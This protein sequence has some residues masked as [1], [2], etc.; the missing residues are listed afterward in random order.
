MTR[1]SARAPRARRSALPLVFLA[2]AGS[3]AR[4]QQFQHQAGLLPGAVVWTEGV[5]CADVDGD[6]DLDVFFADGDG[7]NAP[8]TKRQ[9]VLLINQF[10]PTG[11]LT[12]TDE[13][14][15][16]LG[17]H[18][19]N[20]KAVVTCDVNGDGWI[21][22]LFCNAWDTDTPFLYI[23]QGPANP[24]VFTLESAARG[25][26]AAMSSGGAQF[27]D[28]DD[29]GDPDLLINDAYLGTAARR[30]KVYFN[31]GA[32]VFSNS[33]SAISAAPTKT[34]QMDTQ[35]VDVDNDWDLDFVGL[36]RAANGGTN[37]Y[38]LLNNGAGTFGSAPLTIP[39]NS[40]STYE[41]EVGDLDGDN[42]IDLFL[43]SSSGFAEGAIRNNLVP[44]GAL[45]LTAQATLVDGNDDNEIALLDYDV[46]GDYD[47][48]VGSL[49]NTRETFWTN[50]GA[51][52]F[53]NA[54][55]GVITAQTDSTLDLAV[56]DLDNDGRYDLVTGQGESGN[57]TNKVY[58]NTGAVDTRK[59]VVTALDSPAF[60][61]PAGPFKVHAKIRDQVLDDGVNYVKASARYVIR[62]TNAVPQGSS[63]D[64]AGL[65]NPSLSISAGDGVVWQN[66]L[67]APQT[68]TFTNAPYDHS[69]PTLAQ[70]QTFETALVHPGIYSYVVQP[71]GFAGTIT[72][73]GSDTAVAGTHSG[74][75]LY[76]FSMPDNVGGAGLV[77]HYELVFT[78]WAGN[79]RVTAPL[80]ISL[81]D[82][83][84]ATYC[85]AK[86][87]SLGCVPQITTSGT[88]NTT[89]SSGFTITASNVLNQ[90]NG[91]FFY[92]VNG[93]TAQPFDGGTLCVVGPH[94]RTTL[95]NSGGSVL[96]SD[97]SGAFAL[98]FNTYMAGVTPITFSVGTTVDGQFWSRDP[99]DPFATNITGGIHFGLCQ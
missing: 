86:T 36:C 73:A 20:A 37:H 43:V 25:L 85:T 13:S 82:C 32:G 49:S 74:G 89:A 38:L 76:R 54:G 53:T 57:F 88:P 29:D 30:P 48:I 61:L 60:V 68:I 33:T 55:A 21:D 35:L 17:V 7:F 31:N 28:L 84:I 72:V 62:T 71:A 27:G 63:I 47:V 44:N 67:A 26:T 79:T 91:L 42:D 50:N 23:N 75:Q 58:R 16:R 41:G 6:G 40:A 96:G 64:L 56:A 59:P 65:S 12:F 66:N 97:C 99:A 22:A 24:G 15:A 98:D 70:S 81:R 11:V 51:G 80:S 34:A 52:A 69:L 1:F 5:E 2:A 93:Q 78:D 10:V 9:N 94:I 4:A 19:S 77:L 92:G 95:I 90:K 8:S 87:N 39:S 45:S 46:D 83:S 3:A 18:T 14:V